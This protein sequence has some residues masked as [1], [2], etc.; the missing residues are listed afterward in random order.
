M[1]NTAEMSS[2]FR[3]RLA[4]ALYDEYPEDRVHLKSNVAEIGRTFYQK[5][6]A[7]LPLQTLIHNL[8][9]TVSNQIHRSYN[10]H[11]RNLSTEVITMLRERMDTTLLIYF[12]G[13]IV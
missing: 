5:S 2:P 4:K 12:I 7:L 10:K 3:A 13:N 11:F 1:S 6:W 9:C 8:N